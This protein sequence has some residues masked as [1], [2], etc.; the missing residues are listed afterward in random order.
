MARPLACAMILALLG[1]TWAAQPATSSKKAAAKKTSSARQGAGKAPTRKGAWRTR[2]MAPTPQRYQQ[3]QQ[4]L[5][6]KGY[7][8]PEDAKGVWNQA[9]VDALKQFQSA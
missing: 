5:A 1:L 9:S 8:R 6:S 3:I 2:Q 7:L 4:A